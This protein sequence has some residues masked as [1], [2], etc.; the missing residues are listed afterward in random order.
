MMGL[1]HPRRDQ[2]SLVNLG[3]S[4]EISD[5]SANLAALYR[6][7]RSVRGCQTPYALAERCRESLPSEGHVKEAPFIGS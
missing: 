5:S 2:S 4:I 3:A 7:S 1:P 6:G